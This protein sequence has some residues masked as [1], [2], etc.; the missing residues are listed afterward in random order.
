[1]DTI[2]IPQLNFPS[3]KVLLFIESHNRWVIERDAYVSREYYNCHHPEGKHT[4]AFWAN[5][6]DGRHETIV[7]LDGVRYVACYGGGDTKGPIMR[8]KSGRM[9]INSVKSDN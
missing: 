4:P 6:G 1:M 5:R 3:E 7:L 8:H 9:T 2:R